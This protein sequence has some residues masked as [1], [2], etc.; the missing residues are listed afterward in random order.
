MGKHEKWPGSFVETGKAWG[1]IPGIYS[2]P[3]LKHEQ[4]LFMIIP[5]PSLNVPEMRHR[6]TFFSQFHLTVTMETMT[7]KKISTS[8]LAMYF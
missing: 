6:D 7:V 5:I 2:L 4:T 3:Y 1:F 8:F